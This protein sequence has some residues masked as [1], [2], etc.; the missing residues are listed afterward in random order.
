MTSS[1]R[2]T[3]RPASSPPAPGAEGQPMAG[4]RSGAAGSPAQRTVLGAAG[5]LD[6]ALGRLAKGPADPTHRRVGAQH[7]WRAT[8]TPDGPALLELFDHHADVVTR[9]WGE[10]A[11]WALDQV[12]RLLGEQDDPSGFAAL[13]ADCDLLRRAHHDHPQWRIGATDNLTEALAPAVIEQKVTGPEAFGGLRSLLA[14]YATPAPGPAAT[15]DGPAHGMVVPPTAEQRAHIPSFEFTR[16]GVDGR[17]AAALVRA[18][19]RVPSLERA[20]GRATDGAERSRL[21]QTQPGIGPWTAAKVLQWAYG[22]PDAWSVGDYHA[23]ALISLALTGQKGDDAFADEA[24][25]PY[26]GHRYRVELLVTPLVA[27]AARRGARRTLP[28]H[29]PGVGVNRRRSWR[30]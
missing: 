12:P 25:A 17:R 24:L 15:P 29:V 21:L 20:L 11:D 19:R 23:P 5:R 14:K 8:R 22:D 1:P 30:R 6:M 10:G 13:A 18:M 28:S 16:A 9:A 3:G 26:A 7:W 4:A 2:A 27:H